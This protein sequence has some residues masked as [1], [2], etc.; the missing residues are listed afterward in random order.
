[1]SRENI[2]ID[3][4]QDINIPDFE[5]RNISKA[6]FQFPI[7]EEN[8]NVLVDQAVK[9]SNKHKR[10]KNKGVSLVDPDSNYKSSNER[11]TRIDPDDPFGWILL[12]W[13]LGLIQLMDHLVQLDLRIFLV[14]P[15]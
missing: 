12:F 5:E 4:N 1:M 7:F 9:I 14:T 8:V 6:D 10:K 11:E 15:K 13:A 3:I 2:G